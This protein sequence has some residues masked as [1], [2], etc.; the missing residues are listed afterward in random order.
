MGYPWI[1]SMVLFA[2]KSDSMS[3]QATSLYNQ[4]RKASAS[5]PGPDEG[6]YQEPGN[7]AISVNCKIA[8]LHFWESGIR[9]WFY[10]DPGSFG[11]PHHKGRTLT[12][13]HS[14]TTEKKNLCE[15]ENEWW[16][17][18]QPLMRLSLM[19]FGNWNEQSV[20][21]SSHKKMSIT[22][23]YMGE[24]G[25]SRRVVLSRKKAESTIF[26][27]SFCTSAPWYAL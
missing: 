20:L 19:L 14:L 27:L 3:H 7:H 26:V 6:N 4:W 16:P 8:S 1:V 18:I 12:A 22:E 21:I 5:T 9:P 24:S 2:P 11:I 23:H 25:G 17:T 10:R 13:E 15:E